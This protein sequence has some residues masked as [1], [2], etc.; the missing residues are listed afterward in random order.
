MRKGDIY[1]NEISRRFWVVAG[2]ELR[3]V[4]GIESAPLEDALNLTYIG[5]YL[6]KVEELFQKQHK[7]CPHC[8]KMLEE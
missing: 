3:L 7:Y 4:N 8:G 2:T 1:M 5:Q 6:G